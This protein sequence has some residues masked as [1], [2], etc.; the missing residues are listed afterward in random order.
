MATSIWSGTI[1]FGLVSIPVKLF[2]A[3]TSHDI[4]FNLLHQDCNHRIQLQNYCPTCERVVERAELIKGYQYEKDQ[5]VTI[6]EQ[7]IQSVRPESSS[8]LDIVQFIHLQEV[9]PIYYERT[10][11]LGADKGSRKTFGLLAKAME[12]TQRAAIGKL[13]MRNHEYLALIRPGMKGLIV[14]L[15]LY[16]DEIRENENQV[17]EDLELRSKELN[18]AKELIE[19][20]TEAFQPDQFKNEYVNALE[21]MIESKL[22]GRTLTIVQPKAKPKVQDLMEAL[23]LSVKQ[24][25]MKKPALRAANDEKAAVIRSLK[26]IK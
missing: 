22:K 25:R 5:Y 10:Y 11:Y 6:Q 18:L 23:Q 15:M 2:A 7:D 14:H 13:V 24:T 16:A 12:E 8:N 21:E 26:K 20:L 1:S 17:D 9:D 4:S 19:N 3:T